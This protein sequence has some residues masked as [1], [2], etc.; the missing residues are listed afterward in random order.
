MAKFQNALVVTRHQGMVDYARKIGLIGDDAI[1]V[2]HATKDVVAGKDVIGV[3]PHSLSVLCRSFTEIPLDLPAELRGKEL[4][5]EDME[6]YAG[7]PVTY[8]VSSFEDW[9]SG[10]A[11]EFLQGQLIKE[12]RTGWT[13]EEWEQYLT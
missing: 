11:G 13:D 10:M 1:V 7:A 12:D 4:S 9:V 3:L 2:A 6:K 8:R 5:V